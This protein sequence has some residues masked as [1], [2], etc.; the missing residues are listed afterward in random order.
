M[1]SEASPSFTI[2]HEFLCR[3][4]HFIIATGGKLYIECSWCDEDDGVFHRGETYDA[5]LQGLWIA[6]ATEHLITAHPDR[7]GAM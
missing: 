4:I 3:G 5:S 2:D 1:M 7:I 6:K